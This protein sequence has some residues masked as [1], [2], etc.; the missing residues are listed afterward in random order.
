MKKLFYF[1]LFMFLIS[2]NENKNKQDESIL[3]ALVSESYE[4]VS[5]S[6]AHLDS[7][8]PYKQD[9][10]KLKQLANNAISQSKSHYGI[11][12]YKEFINHVEHIMYEYNGNEY[13]PTFD[14]SSLQK[15]SLCAEVKFLEYVAINSIIR[16]FHYYYFTFDIHRIIVVPDKPTARVGETYNAKIYFAANDSNS[17]FKLIVENDTIESCASWGTPIFSITQKNKGKYSHEAGLILNNRGK[18]L[19]FPFRINYEVK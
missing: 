16:D 13:V 12:A 14:I 6:T 8:S 11:T 18:E 15:N 19:T 7:L 3:D 17:P 10:V 1:T 4:Y 9:I 2:C 5:Q